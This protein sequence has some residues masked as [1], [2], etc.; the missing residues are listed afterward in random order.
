MLNVSICQIQYER[1]TRMHVAWQPSTWV[2]CS[3]AH[4]LRVVAAKLVV[5]RHARSVNLP[6]I[7][8]GAY[9]LAARYMGVLTADEWVQGENTA[10]HWSAMR[11]HVEIV[12]F[13]LMHGADKVIRNKQDKIPIDLCQ[14]CWSNAYRY[15]REVL[16]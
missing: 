4:E 10:L 14:P 1:A 15:T 16:A 3:I 12:K 8:T 6:E 11:G 2:C 13:L 5:A 9:G 7:A